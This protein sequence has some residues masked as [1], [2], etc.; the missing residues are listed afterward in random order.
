MKN[1]IRILIVTIMLVFAI[2][3]SHSYAASDKQKIA[4]FP[5]DKSIAPAGLMPFPNAISLISN[6]L[7]NKL[8][9][10]PDFKIIDIKN[11]DSI[12]KNKGLYSKYRQMLLDY[13]NSFI[14]D[15]DTLGIISDKLGADKILI[16]SGGFDMQTVFLKR[17]WLNRLEIPETNIITPTYRLNTTLTLIDAQTGLVIWEKIYKKDLDAKYYTAPSPAFGENVMATQQLKSFSKWV[18][19][20]ADAELRFILSRSKYTQVHSEIIETQSTDIDSDNASKDGIMTKDGHSF[21]T[22]SNYLLK[23]RKDNYTNYIKNNL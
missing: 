3:N 9:K 1:F 2:T 12:I 11:S 8:S 20:E 4:I 18:A 23:N 5:I 22:D 6:D 10:N 14:L 7:E 15:Y 13:K 21:S 17:G 19:F 16:I